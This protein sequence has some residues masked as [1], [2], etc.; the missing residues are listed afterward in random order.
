[1]H[2]FRQD[3]IDALIA[4]HRYRFFEEIGWTIILLFFTVYAY[5]IA[6]IFGNAPFS[7]LLPLAIGILVYALYQLIGSTLLITKVHKTGV[8]SGEAFRGERMR[9]FTVWSPLS[10]TAGF[11][12]A[13]TLGGV[14]GWALLFASGILASSLARLTVLADRNRF[15]AQLE[16]HNPGKKVKHL[17]DVLKQ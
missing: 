7:A 2:A 8:R 5:L 14:L 10:I 9:W 1:M 13:I 17:S 4:Y 3:Q 6:T 16:A 12:L 15:L 11:V